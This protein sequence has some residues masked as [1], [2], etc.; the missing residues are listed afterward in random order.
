MWFWTAD[1]ETG[2]FIE[3][4]ETL[5]EAECR[6]EEYEDEDK[7][8]GSFTE[9]FYDVVDEDHVS[10]YKDY[11]YEVVINYYTNESGYSH[12]ETIDCGRTSVRFSAKEWL[13]GYGD[14]E[15]NEG[16]FTIDLHFWDSSKEPGSDEPSFTDYYNSEGIY[17]PETH[18]SY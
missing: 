3:S 9:N 2:S 4:F 16:W 17:F 11:S 14:L 12:S 8:N 7:E 5:R 10:V 15:F 6:I 13:D 18:L 1:R